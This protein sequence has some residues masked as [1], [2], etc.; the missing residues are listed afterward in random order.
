MCIRI[1]VPIGPSHR[2]TFLIFVCFVIFLICLIFLISLR[3]SFIFLIFRIFS[4]MMTMMMYD[5][6][7]GG[8]PL[9]CTLWAYHYCAPYDHISVPI[10]CIRICV[11]IGAWAQYDNNRHNR[12]N[13]IINMSITIFRTMQKPYAYDHNA[14]RIGTIWS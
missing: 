6:D 8:I 10:M 7:D 2:E 14:I 12:H 3:F 11:P 5:D 1:C 9:L 4:M 13:M